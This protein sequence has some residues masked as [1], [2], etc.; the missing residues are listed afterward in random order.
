MAFRPLQETQ[1]SLGNLQDEVNRLFERIWHAGVSTGPFDGQQWAPVID[2]DEFAEYYTLY[3]EVPGVDAGS[4]E[5]SYVDHELTIRGEKPKPAG[6]EEADR[7]LRCERR[8]GAFC[9]TVA[10]PHGIDAEGLSAECR[11][12][13]LEITI[14]KSESSRPTAIKSDVAGD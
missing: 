7:S 14:P 13:V 12:G 1:L 10:L 2:L 9:R 8:F 6:A 11:N 3:A 5:L 4:V